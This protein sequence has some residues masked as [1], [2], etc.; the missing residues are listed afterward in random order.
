MQNCIYTSL[1]PFKK[2]RQ[3]I[4]L[5]PDILSF[6]VRTD[7]YESVAAAVATATVVM[8]MVA[9]TAIVMVAAMVVIASAPTTVNRL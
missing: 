7:L 8:V 9:A 3:Y 2:I 1:P 6:F 4:R 5:K